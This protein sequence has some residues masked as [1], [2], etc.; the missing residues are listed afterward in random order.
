MNWLCSLNRK[1]YQRR[2]NHYMRLTNKNI[3]QDNLWRGRFYMRQYGSADFVV[4]DDKSG[5]DLYLRFIL[6]DRQTGETAITNWYSV[7]EVC[8]LDGHKLFE[9]M[10]YFICRIE[11]GKDAIF[12]GPA[13]YFKEDS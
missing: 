7:N 9:I 1:K 8:F 11:Y 2:I 13:L 4:Y 6:Y 12:N 5:A 10:N 3:E